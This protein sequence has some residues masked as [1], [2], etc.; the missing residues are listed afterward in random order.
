MYVLYIF[1]L[2]NKY[3]ENSLE[4]NP[5]CEKD[6]KF[7]L[8]SHSDEFNLKSAS[9]ANLGKLHPA[10]VTGFCDGEACFHLAIGENSRYKIGYYV[11]PGFSIA[12][13]KKDEE[14][15]LLLQQFFGGVGVVKPSSRPNMVEY[16]ILAIKDL[17][18]ILNHFDLYPLISKKKGDYLLFK[19]ALELIKNKQHLTV[20]GFNLILAIR[21]SINKGLPAKLQ[22]KFPYIKGKEIPAV[23]VPDS[24]NPYWVAG[25]VDAEGCFFVKSLYNKNNELRFVLGCQITQHSRDSLLMHKICSFFNCGRVEVS[26]MIYDNYIVTK[27]LDINKIII[28]FFTNFP[29]LGSKRKDFEGWAEVAKLM[30]SKAHHTKDGCDKILKIKLQMNTF[31]E[32]DDNN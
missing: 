25:F 29:I 15:L 1:R 17:D 3:T 9:S 20:E 18:V 13:H 22:E 4:L 7:G 14:L 11:N 5:A 16:R 24:L 28:P 21:A 26:R 8:N 2:L 23:V 27:L 31:R 6:P 12:L 30:T 19:E 10:Y 32:E